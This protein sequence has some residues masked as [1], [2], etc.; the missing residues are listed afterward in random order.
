MKN[1]YKQLFIAIASLGLL[2]QVSTASAGVISFDYTDTVNL[3]DEFVVDV[4]GDI[5]FDELYGFYFD[6]ESLTNNVS[7]LDAVINPSFD[8]GFFND[9]DATI[10]ND[11]DYFNDFDLISGN[12]LLASLTFSADSIGS[13]T[14]SLIGDD[15]NF[16]G[17][18]TLFNGFTDIDASFD[19]NVVDAIKDVPEPPVMA[20]FAFGLLA[21]ARSRKRQS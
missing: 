4:Y 8:A 10:V 2:L 14:I 1:L 18:F 20:I 13:D 17:F 12:V 16:G 7:Y 6:I 5:G 19:I 21:L 11:F 9:I 3:G 15:F